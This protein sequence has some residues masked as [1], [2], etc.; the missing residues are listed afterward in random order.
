MFLTLAMIPLVWII[1]TAKKA[2]AGAHD[3]EPIVLE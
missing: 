1:G 3:E 2:A